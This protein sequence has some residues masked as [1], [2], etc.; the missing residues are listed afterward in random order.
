MHEHK[1]DDVWTEETARLIKINLAHLHS[2]AWS[3]DLKDL[4]RPFRKFCMLWSASIAL[5]TQGQN[6]QVH[7][8]MKMFHSGDAFLPSTT[9]IATKPTVVGRSMLLAVCT[10]IAPPTPWPIK[11][12]GG[13]DSP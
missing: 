10:A 12:T 13:G 1:H 7:I 5:P 6:S 9:S 8:N 4:G 3:M 2:M 11:M